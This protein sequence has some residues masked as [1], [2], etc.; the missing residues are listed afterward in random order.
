MTV[1]WGSEPLLLH[2]RTCLSSVTSF[3]GALRILQIPSHCA[4]REEGGSCPGA[5]LLW[6]E[7]EY[8]AMALLVHSPHGLDEKWNTLKF[9][10]FITRV[11]LSDSKGFCMSNRLL[12]NS[13]AHPKA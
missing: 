8:R 11:R 6:E 5:E 4:F 12:E 13:D 3:S 9:Q 7:F 2:S 1:W 10:L